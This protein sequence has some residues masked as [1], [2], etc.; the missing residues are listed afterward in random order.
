MFTNYLKVALRNL[1][2]HKLFAFINIFGLSLG[3]ACGV[4]IMLYVQSE[5]SFDESFTKKNNLYRVLTTRKQVDGAIDLGAYQPM[6]LVPALKTE[7]PEIRYATRFSTGGT[8]LSYGERAFT[9]TVMFTD[10]DV[11]KM[12]DM[13]FLAGNPETALQNPNEIVLTRSMAHKYFG[14]EN[15]LGKVLRM[16]TR[17]S[18]EDYVVTGV[19]EHMPVNSSLQFDAL[20]NMMKHSMYDRAKDRWTSSNGSAFLLLDAGT[21]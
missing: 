7:F 11:F 5:L 15:P 6:P 21:S 16:R 10:P 19:T 9:E 3:I 14:D 18:D 17:A 20:A 4:I 12:F 13:T 1:A 2:R 8:I